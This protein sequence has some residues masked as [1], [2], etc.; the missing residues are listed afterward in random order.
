MHLESAP[1]RDDFRRARQRVQGA[2]GS[3]TLAGDIRQLQADGRDNTYVP[4]SS[5]SGPPNGLCWLL[6]HGRQIPLKVGLNS[7]GRLPDNDVVID[8]A[9]VSR[10][11]CAIV[12]HSDLS[13]ELHDVASKNGT[14]IN[15][16]KMGGP[17]RLQDGDEITLCER[18]LVFVMKSGAPTV[19]RSPS[20][21]SHLADD[22]TL[23]G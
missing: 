14:T 19:D 18:R 22:H 1:R 9:T 3:H 21:K 12:V 8:D 13:V 10:R 17:T 15:G 23:A 20:R 4:G 2:L 16:S 6:D 7:I 5:P 11:H